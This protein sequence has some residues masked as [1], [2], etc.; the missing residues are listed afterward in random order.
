MDIGVI[1]IGQMGAAMARSL[2]RAGHTVTVYNRTASKT[3]PLAALGAR[4][5]ATLADAC[6]GDAV[7]TMLSD[8]PAVRAMLCA[9]H[10]LL[11]QLAPMKTVHISAST[12]SPA[13]VHDLADRHAERNQRF[14]S[15]PVLG[16]PD[17]A[18]AGTLSALAAGDADT[19][20][21]VRPAVEAFAQRVFIVGSAPEAANIVKLACNSLI[22]TLIE[23][24]GETLALI[25]KS[26]LV[27]PA[28]FLDVLL[29]TILSSPTFRPYAEHLRDDNFEPGF[30]LPLAL[31]DMELALATARDKAV[32]L[33]I[34]S[35]I[36]D[37]MVAA[38]ATGHGDQDWSALALLAQEAAGIRKR[39]A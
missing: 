19:I 12:I 27:E 37:H 20:E 14:V 28:V 21:A 24:L 13:L 29:Q 31:K 3:E 38:I 36:R 1:G 17:A 34:I 9:P 11:D 33:P 32:P 2:L 35:V 6:R 23:A 5:A 16:R 26:R 39:A 7:I 25:M 22:A 10:A 8:D 30:R 18:E 15:I 4:V